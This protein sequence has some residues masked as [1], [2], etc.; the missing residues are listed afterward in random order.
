MVPMQ[1][2]SFAVVPKYGLKSLPKIV[3][4]EMH[5]TLKFT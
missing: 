1:D 4:L 2:P 5:G 3:D